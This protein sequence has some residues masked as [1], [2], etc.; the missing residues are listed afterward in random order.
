MYQ[1][2]FCNKVA[3]LRPEFCEIFKSIFFYKPPPV[4]ASAKMFFENILDSFEVSQ[5]NMK[6]LHKLIQNSKRESSKM[7]P[8]AKIVNE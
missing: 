7:E 2:L 1:S 3:A 8:S 4:V 5:S 6:S